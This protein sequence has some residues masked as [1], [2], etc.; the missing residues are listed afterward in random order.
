MNKIE[1]PNLCEKMSEQKHK[2][3][4]P[5][6]FFSYKHI[7]FDTI[8]LKRD[9]FNRNIE[10]CEKDDF[11]S[12][13]YDS[14]ILKFIEHLNKKLYIEI[15][16]Y[17][18]EYFG[19]LDN[20]Q[21]ILQSYSGGRDS[22]YLLLKN[23]KD[24]YNVD[25]QYNVFNPA[26][27]KYRILNEF[28]YL[29][30]ILHIAK[31]YPKRISLNYKNV[32]NTCCYNLVLS[33][34]PFNVYSLVTGMRND[35]KIKE[36]QM[37]L[38][39]GDCGLSFLDELKS[40]YRSAAKFTQYYDK[41]NKIPPLKFPL[42]KKLKYDII[43]E[44]VDN[45]LSEHI[46]FNTCASPIIENFKIEK[47][48]IEISISECGNCDTC[49]HLKLSLNKIPTQYATTTVRLNYEKIKK[50]VKI[51]KPINPSD[52]DDDICDAVSEC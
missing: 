47:N 34:Q 28:I 50:L 15:K 31:Q 21:V 24:G 48:Y 49:N 51:G 13:Y 41:Y 32:C 20:K 44:L 14:D 18:T 16:K 30:N 6:T 17:T 38:I 5:E 1:L 10:T 36:C 19:K 37:G 43:K 12:Y 11:G 39:S 22:T 23:L 33:Q 2:I 35:S 25:I 9:E 52:K 29:W 46:I 27:D 45:S 26:D 3:L 8:S 4:N 42:I 40:L 7:N